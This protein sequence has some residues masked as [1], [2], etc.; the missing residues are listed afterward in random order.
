MA[1][2]TSKTLLDKLKSGDEI[3]YQEFYA[4]YQPFVL[5]RGRRMGL[6]HT[7]CD[8]LLQ[9]VMLEFFRQSPT[10]VYDTAKGHFR[11]FFA[12]I[13]RRRAINILNRRPAPTLELQDFD[14]PDEADAEPDFRYE[15]KLHL[16]HQAL[17]ILK[18]R[19]ELST[20][21]AFYLYGIQERKAVEVAGYLNISANSVYVAKNRCVAMLQ[22]IVRELNEAEG[23][24]AL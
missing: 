16:F 20:Y 6:S 24:E 22:T 18:N 5:M 1:F 23:E 19:V 13:I 4:V 21:E 7:E 14:L 17:D 9:Q 3:S 10:F 11:S 8:D 12:T 15:W 2:T